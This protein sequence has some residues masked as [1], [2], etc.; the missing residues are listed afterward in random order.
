MSLSAGIIGLP[1]VGKSTLFNALCSGNAAME[2]Y[3]FCTIDPNHGMAAVPDDRLKRIAGHITTA[4]IVPAFL[5]L[6]DIAGLVKGASQGA[7]LG[8]QFLGHIKDVDAVVH[9]VRCF[10]DGDVVHVDG[11]VDPLRDAGTIEIE[12]LLKDLDT[13]TSGVE[14]IAKAAKSGEKELKA[15][16]EIYELV[17][18]GLAKGTPVR[19]MAI[20]EDA[21]AAIAGM[22]LITAKPMLYVGNVSETDLS[23]EAKLPHVKSLR[24]F[25]ADRGIPFVPICARIEAELGELAEDER[26]EFL[27]SLGLAESG[28]ARLAREIYA[29]LGLQSFFTWNEKEL[30]AWTLTKGSTAPQAAGAIHSDFEKGFVRADVYSVE[31]LETF[32]TEPALRAAGKIRSEGRDYVV[33]DGEIL[34]FKFTP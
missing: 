16:L 13:A 6:I 19:K 4:R 30:H 29:L 7:G 24:K 11:S 18:D 28:L 15:R 21:L 3:P 5:E 17:R 8:N 34:F 12:L 10:E 23:P 2:N 32:H 27:A 25:T 1:N 20:D 31:E 33:K 14:R 9:V 22:H 26:G